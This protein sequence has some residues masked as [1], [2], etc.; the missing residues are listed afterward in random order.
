MTGEGQRFEGRIALVTGA[1]SGIGR[2]TALRLAAEGAAV[3]LADLDEAG[4]RRTAEQMDGAVGAHA[5]FRLDICD[6]SE[7]ETVLDHIHA[8]HGRLDVLVN[9]AGISAAAPLDQM[10]LSEW[11]RV[12]EV[13]VDGAFLATKHGLRAMRAGGGSIVHVSSASGLKAAAGAC[14]YSA[15]KAAVCM[16]AKAAAK[17]CRDNDIPVRVNTV[18]P[19]GVK[20]PMWNTMPFFRD[21]VRETG[22]EAAALESID[23][24]T[25]GGLAQPAD[26]AAAILFLAS[27]DARHIN[28]IDLLVD[29]GYVL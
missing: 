14:A 16:L 21:L 24:N 13:N 27:D 9:S 19:G 1:A 2:E 10:S 8:A 26:I 22:S 17:E 25:P 18:C 20:T 7:W 12:F 28:G 29:G 11:R 23:S 4:A 5:V 6:E 15:S 3:C